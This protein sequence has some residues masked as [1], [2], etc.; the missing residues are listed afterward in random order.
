M[1]EL[2]EF[3]LKRITSKPDNL[4][5]EEKKDHTGTIFVI[6]L[7]DEDKGKVIGKNGSNIKAI[8]AILSILA[9]PKGE[10]FFLK[11]E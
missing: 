5:I 1:K 11:I 10:I 9:R 4:T 7:A 6:T 8:K 2:L 3:I